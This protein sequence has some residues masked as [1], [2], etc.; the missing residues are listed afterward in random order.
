MPPPSY[1]DYKLPRGRHGLAREE[2]A[3]NQRWRLIGAAAD[4]FAER[5]VGGTTSRLIALRAGVSSYTFYEFFSGVEDVLEASFEVAA[6]SLGEVIVAACEERSDGEA[7]L[8]AVIGAALA[9]GAAE[10]GLAAVIGLPLAVSQPAVAAGRAEL[11][12]KIGGLLDGCRSGKPTGAPV[13]T[14]P[15]TV[16][17]ALELGLQLLGAGSED[18]G[19]AGELGE[20]ALH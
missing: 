5:G 20:L 6:Q 16:A 7:G 8:A 18:E 17:A 4:V 12:K 10:P 9:F 13:S 1:R 11:L 14:G 3:A 19:L 15:V 2:V